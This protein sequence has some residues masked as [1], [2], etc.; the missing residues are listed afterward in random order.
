MPHD[1]PE[2][3]RALIDEQAEQV[4]TEQGR[5][6]QIA[7][8]EKLPDPTGSIA[9]A[10]G[11]TLSI[12]AERLRQQGRSAQALAELERGARATPFVPAWTSGIVSQ[13]YERYLRAELLHET[14]RDDEALRWYATFAENS[15]YDLVYL[16]PSLY[17]QA[18]IYDARGQNALASERYRQFA[19]LWKDCD[20]QLRPLTTNARARIARLQ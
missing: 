17:R 14:G 16:A 13:A 1:R 19:E 9:L 20:P 5:V 7:E 3:G 18:Q 11:F 15:P 4:H 10:K 12:G 2:Q 6:Q 8:L